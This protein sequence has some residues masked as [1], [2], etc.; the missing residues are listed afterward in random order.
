MELTKK[1]GLAVVL[2][3]LAAC[4]EGV[5]E[6]EAPAGD[7]ELEALGYDLSTT[8][9]L[10]GKIRFS[11][12]QVHTLDAQN[13]RGAYTFKGR[14][15][16]TIAATLVGR[17][18]ATADTVLSLYR[19]T[20]KGT[21][22]FVT[23]S[24]D[25]SRTDKSSRLT[26][27]LS[28]DATY[29]LYTRVKSLRTAKV[30]VS[31][32]CAA[33]FC[34]DESCPLLRMMVPYCP[35]RLVESRDAYGCT[36]M[37]TCDRSCGGR[38]GG[39]CASDAYCDFGSHC[40]ATD[41]PGTCVQQPQICTREYAPVCGCDGNTYGNRCTAAAA[42]VSVKQSGACVRECPVYP[43]ARCIGGNVVRGEVGPDGCEGPP[44]CSFTCGTRGAGGCSD[45]YWC[46]REESAMC[47][48]ADAPGTCT[49]PGEGFCTK[50]Y[51]PV[52][53]CDG[54][55]YGNACMADAAQAS[56]DHQGPCVC[57]STSTTT[58]VRA[59]DVPG[60]WSGRGNWGITWDFRLDGTVTR[61]DAVS[62]CPAG[63]HCL[64]SG[65]VT[66]SGTWQVSFGKVSLTWK[67]ANTTG[68]VSL[69]RTLTPYKNA[70]G[71]VNLV[72]TT[73]TPRID[74]GRW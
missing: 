65:I 43:P 22:S 58:T 7:E 11:G 55:T 30:A 17:E 64:W 34:G 71:A 70:C 12:T 53:G 45:G 23:S 5:T 41:K 15:G 51:A 50:E 36:Q 35:G 66:N 73:S 31:L 16:S 62:P 33:G 37:P 18:P 3:A 39:K 74:Y 54:Q 49:P 14:A 38:G 72:E 46:R 20:A 28:H 68:G 9:P 57:A 2:A 24:D 26:S 61:T 42:G 52:C 67:T 69:P 40:G 6:T 29:L 27:K 13:T 4:G 59:A 48:R 19:Q 25:V 21:W 32:D 47:G 63:H 60:T 56:I 10:D 8:V 44:I 1:V